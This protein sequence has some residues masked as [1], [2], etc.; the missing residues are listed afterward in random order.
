MGSSHWYEI[1]YVFYNT[2]GLGIA[3]HINPFIN[4]TKEV[5]HLAMLMSRMWVSFIHDLDPNHHGGKFE[6]FFMEW[7][8]CA[9]AIRS[10]L[11]RALASVQ[12][13][14]GLRKE[15]LLPSHQL[16]YAA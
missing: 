7:L 16:W 1:P 11:R 3:E 12:R 2:H 10:S 14:S 4:A 8:A 9:N 15:L 5:L 13:Y 6:K